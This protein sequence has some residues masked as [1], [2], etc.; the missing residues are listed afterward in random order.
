MDIKYIHETTVHNTNA[1]KEIV[2]VIIERYKIKSVID[3]GCGIGTWLAIFEKFG[4]KNYIGI[5]GNYVDRRMMMIEE[6]FFLTLDLSKSFNLNKKFDLVLCLEV[7]EHL[8]EDSAKNFIECLT[9]LGDLIIFSAAIPGQGGQNHLNEQFPDYWLDIFNNL[10]YNL[11]DDIR[12]EFWNNQKIE[13]WYRQNIMVLKK[14]ATSSEKIERKFQIHPDLYK[15]K[16]D[17]IIF[18]KKINDNMIQGRISPRNAFK[19]FI[20]S[21]I[22]YFI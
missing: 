22:K 2:P 19:I 14:N 13:W 20:K 17:E 11:I 16:L 21:L 12:P 10:G 4:I 15:R 6:S 1:A 7:A 3:I 9:K 5:D 8:E 18:L